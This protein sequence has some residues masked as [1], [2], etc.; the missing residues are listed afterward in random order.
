VNGRFAQ[1][2]RSASDTTAENGLLAEPADC[3]FLLTCEFHAGRIS[4]NASD[5]I[6][7]LRNDP[8]GVLRTELDR[9]LTDELLRVSRHIESGVEPRIYKAASGWCLALKA[10]RLILMRLSPEEPERRQ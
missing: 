6:S 1:S 5:L 10:A 9:V 2:L 4:M 3:A 8:D 7:R